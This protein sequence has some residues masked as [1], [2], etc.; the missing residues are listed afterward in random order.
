MQSAETIYPPVPSHDDSEMRCVV[1]DSKESRLLWREKLPE[2]LDSAQFSYKGE[3]NYHGRIVECVTCGHRYVHP[4]PVSANTLYAEVEDPFYLQTEKYRVQTF[5]DFLNLKEAHVPTKGSLLDVGCYTGVFLQIAKERGYEVSGVELSTWAASVA[6]SRGFT[7]HETPIEQCSALP[8]T[9][10]TICAFDV[11]EHLENPK[12]AAENIRKKLNKGGCF[13]AIVPDMASW[14]AKILGEHHWLV[15]LMHYHYFN[16]TNFR[17]MLL[18][19]GFSR[20]EVFRSPPYR[21]S[22]ERA[23]NWA[24]GT[25][26]SPIFN[27]LGRI[28][29]V[30]KLQIRL[31]AGIAVLC[32]ND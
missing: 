11:F 25:P 15:I 3:K 13:F 31:Q 12:T 28:P 14:H 9:Y 18:R 27:I 1:C 22:I 23:R 17:R 29:L 4:F 5:M 8:G 19:A 24:K 32:Y 10:D 21:L 2:N 7:V 6:R 20:V 30:N 16:K 26:L